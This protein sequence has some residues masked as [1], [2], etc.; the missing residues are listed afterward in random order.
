[1]PQSKMDAL[2]SWLNRTFPPVPRPVRLPIDLN[3]PVDGFP[4]CDCGH[5][6]NPH[7]HYRDGNDCSMCD[8]R[9]Y[10]ARRIP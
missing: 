10:T 1:M 4:L 3:V 7:R 8:C 5:P 9:T 2:R 6:A